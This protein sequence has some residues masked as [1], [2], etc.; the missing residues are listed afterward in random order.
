MLAIEAAA[1]LG[2]IAGN[3][4]GDRFFQRNGLEYSVIT[5]HGDELTFTQEFVKGDRIVKADETCRMQMSFDGR[6]RVF[7]VDGF[8]SEIKAPETTTIIQ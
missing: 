6:N 8:V 2:G 4:A 5:G 1:I 7:P 3:K